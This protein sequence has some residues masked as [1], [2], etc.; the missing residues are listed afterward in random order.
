MRQ[1]RVLLAF[2]EAVHLIDKHDGAPPLSSSN[3]RPPDGFADFFHAAQHS[4][5][6]QKLRVKGAGHQ[7]GNRRLAGARRPPEDA[8]VRLT[9]F[10]RQAQRHACAQQMALADHIAQGLGAQ[11]F[12]ERGVVGSRQ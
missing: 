4:A 3:L 12:G 2:V 11:L 10:K 6:A 7:A 1:E 8:T 9:R 5:D